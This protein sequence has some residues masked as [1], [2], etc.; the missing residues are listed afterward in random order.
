[1]ETGT[2]KWFNVQK[3]FGFIVRDDD[4][5]G[6]LPDELWFHFNEGQ[7]IDAVPGKSE[8]EFVGKTVKGSA[9]R[10]PKEGDRVRFR[11]IGDGKGRSKASPWG[12]Y[13]HYKRAVEIIGKR[14]PPTTYRVLETMNAIGEKPPEPKVLWEGTNLE[15]LLKRC[16]LP[17]GNQSPSADPLLPYYS[18]SDNIFEIHRWFEQKTEVG[19]EKCPDPRPLSGVNRQFERITHGW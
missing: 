7:I 2:V 19:W 3:R 17:R 18:D 1:M 8:P 4:L 13:S 14:P 6:Y 16:P 11:V 5:D 15:E 12:Y 9:L 10:D